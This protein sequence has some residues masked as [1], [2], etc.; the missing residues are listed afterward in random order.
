MKGICRLY[1]IETELM[2]SHIIPKF[3]IEHMKRT[4]SRFLRFF[5][6]PNKRVQD[7]VKEYLLSAKA[8]QDFSKREKWFAERIFFP[9]L[10]EDQRQLK[11]D[12]NLFYFS[13][14][15]LWRVLIGH[16][17]HPSL[18][19]EQYLDRLKEV[20]G[21]WKLYLRGERK[22]PKYNKVYIYL[23]GR[24]LYHDIDSDEVDYYLTRAL[25]ATIVANDPPTFVSVYAKFNRF[26]FW[27]TIYGGNTTGL[28]TLKISP[29][30]GVIN[31]PQNCKDEYM[32]SFFRNR[33]IEI[34]TLPTVSE[35]QKKIIEDDFERNKSKFL[36]SDAADSMRNDLMLEKQ[37][38]NR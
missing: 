21:D 20:S 26:I 24:V 31:I 12:D 4:G 13:I 8:E 27:A 14:S 18:K 2:E 25:D 30:G 15:L 5:S 19:D 32:N 33:I 29:T 1:D 28:S 36:K 22:V 37:R 38:K 23:T 34:G 17:N 6:N 11:Y 9:Y 7:G 16:L 35:K 10:N 3:V